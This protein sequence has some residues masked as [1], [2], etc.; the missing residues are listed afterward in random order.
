MRGDAGLDRLIEEGVP[1]PID[2]KPTLSTLGF[3]LGIYAIGAYLLYHLWRS[4]RG[5]IP[6][7]LACMVFAGAVEATDIR[8]THSYYYIRELIM[9]EGDPKW[10][11][12]SIAMAWALV[13]HSTWLVT[14]RLPVSPWQRPF[15]GAVLALMIDLVLDPTGA[16]ARIVGSLAQICD[17]TNLPHDSAAGLGLWVWCVPSDEHSLIWGIPYANFFAWGVVVLSWSFVSTA[18]RRMFRLVDQPSRIDL[19]TIACSAATAVVSYAIVWGVIKAYTPIVMH[20]VPEW[21]L[22]GI[23]FVPGI[24]VLLLAGGDRT[25]TKLDTAAWLFPAGALAYCVFAMMVD[26]LAGRGSLGFV[27]YVIGALIAC[28][29][30]MAWVVLGRRGLHPASRP[31]PA[32]AE[33]L[34][35]AP[36]SSDLKRLARIANMSN[37]AARNYLITQAYHDLSVQLARKVGGP[38]ANWCTFATW[39][40]RTAGESIR[41]EEVPDWALSLLREEAR[42]EAALAAA[43]VALGDKGHEAPDVFDLARDVL[44]RV[45]DQ[46]GDGNRK[47][48]AE[49]A[50]LFARLSACFRANGVVDDAA[51]TFLLDGLRPGPS[52]DGGQAVVRE[53]FTTYRDAARETDAVRKAELMLLA[54]CLIGLHEQTRLQANIAAALDAPIDVMATDGPFATLAEHAHG[55]LAG[56]L[57]VVG[58]PCERLARDAWQRIATS[59]AMHLDMPDGSAIGLGEDPNESLDARF[60]RDLRAPTLPALRELMTRYGAAHRGNADTAATDWASLDQRMRFIIDLFRL[61]QQTAGMFEQPFTAKQR[62]VHAAALPPGSM[63]PPPMQV[64]GA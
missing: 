20:G 38:D 36:D 40:S 56:L 19:R 15:V 17:A 4:R 39:A 1:M 57:S 64:A 35:D 12:L 50:P 42:L 61:S 32:R 58:K 33:L 6:L 59:A 44:A 52:A 29:A 7:V 21:L 34:E 5:D 9:I 37:A 13:L 31:V 47:V 18:M 23:P 27:V 53:A 48:Y 51:F 30:A 41:D 24:V 8:S 3:E 43:R 55:E 14:Q 22:L 62:Q 26:L 25:D 10:F 11:P 28:V 16:S 46:I 2:H 54:N 45:S 60:P 49:L 63:P